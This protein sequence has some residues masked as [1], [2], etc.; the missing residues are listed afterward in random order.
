MTDYS[1][2]AYNPG[3]EYTLE[4]QEYT[5]PLKFN[6]KGLRDGETDYAKPENTKRIVMVGD[7]YI[8]AKEVPVEKR[9]SEKLESK[10]N[11]F[12]KNVGYEVINMGYGGFG[13][14]SETILLEKEGSKYGPDII[15]FNIF[16]GNDVS[17]IDFGI[18]GSV[19]KELFERHSSLE[20]VEIKVTDV[21]KLKHFVFRNYFTLTY[22]RMLKKRIGN[23]DKPDALV[24]VYYSDI[25][26]LLNKKWSEDTGKN[27]QSL[28]QL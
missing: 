19:P 11:S 6:S 21:Q 22:F 5:I 20:N 23:L 28:M 13:P 10:L 17:K 7:S 1:V 12:S 8:I 25:S 14:T 24:D 27:L 3:Y 26:N 9:A 18:A 4:S 16:V 2:F 15:L